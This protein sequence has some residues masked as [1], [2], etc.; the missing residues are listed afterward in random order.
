VHSHCQRRLANGP[1]TLRACE[2]FGTCLSRG[3]GKSRMPG[4]EGAGAR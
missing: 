3:A 2:P 4:S 1:A